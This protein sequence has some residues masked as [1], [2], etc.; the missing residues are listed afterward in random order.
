MEI[1]ISPG[2]LGLWLV[3]P[4]TYF[5]FGSDVNLAVLVNSFFCVLKMIR[6]WRLISF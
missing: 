2:C 6:G 4:F 1:G 3:R 5:Y